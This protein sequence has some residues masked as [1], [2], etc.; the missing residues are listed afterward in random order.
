MGRLAVILGLAMCADGMLA[1]GR[2]GAWASAWRAMARLFSG[3]TNEYL[4][5]VLDLTESYGRKAPDARKT[6][7]G[8]EIAA[9]VLM[10]SLGLRQRGW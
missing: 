9:G 1:I 3:P 5:G 8:L 6:L 4:E 7:F 2:P 10:L